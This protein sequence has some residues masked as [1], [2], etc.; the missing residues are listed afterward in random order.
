MYP[1][2]YRTLATL[3]EDDIAAVTS[4]YPAAN[5][6][7]TYGQLTG[8]F[9]TAGG[10]PIL[11][12]NIWARETSTGKVYSVVSDFLT[13]GNGYFRLYA[14]RG[15]VHAEC[16]VDRRPTSPADRA[17][18]PIRVTSSSASFQAPHPIAPVALGG[19]SGPADRDYRGL[20]RDGDLP[21]RR[22][23]Q[24]VGKL[25]RLDARV[26]PPPRS[27]RRAAR[28][29]SGTTVTFTATV[30]GVAPTGTVNFKDGGTTISRLRRGGAQRL[31]QQQDRRVQ[32]QRAGGRRPQHRCATTAVMPANLAS[33]S[34]PLSQVIN[35]AGRQQQ[36]G[37][38]ECRCSGLGVEHVF[39]WGCLPPV[40]CEQR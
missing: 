24:C 13:Q 4:L 28:P 15:D 14:S 9:T 12:A 3:H 37:I 40:G 19:G 33:T 8:S 25:Q 1:I 22:N 10:T 31:G 34:N 26:R 7:S 32:Q 18:A 5:V 21:S 27:R 6:G 23:G 36:C 17:S 39:D 35:R 30:A 20:C 11:G 16:R 38:G 29:R 2:A